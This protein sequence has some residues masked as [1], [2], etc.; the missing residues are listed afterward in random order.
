MHRCT[1]GYLLETF[2][3]LPYLMSSAFKCCVSN[4]HITRDQEQFHS[5]IPLQMIGAAKSESQKKENVLLES[6]HQAASFWLRQHRQQ[7]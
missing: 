4:I 1:S 2:L 7:H 6:K 3:Q 5:H